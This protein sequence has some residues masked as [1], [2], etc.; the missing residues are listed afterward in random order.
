MFDTTKRDPKARSSSIKWI[1]KHLARDKKKFIIMVVGIIITIVFRTIIPYFIGLMIDEAILPRDMD[2]LATYAIIILGVGLVRILISYITIYITN[3]VAWET[4]K[5]IRVEFF[6]KMQS[7]PLKFHNTVR[8]GDLMALATNDMNQLGYMV[9]PGIRLM[10]EAFLG[11]IAVI[12]FTTSL[13]ARFTLYLSPFFI[14]YLIAV[15]SY[16]RKMNPISQTF[17]YKWSLISRSAQD[18]ITGVR[19]VRAFNGEEFEQ[20]QF[21]D[22]V[23]DFKNAWDKRQMITAKYWPLLIIY[24]TIGFSFV[25]GVWLVITGGLTLGEL[26]GIN[27]ML[28][29]LIMPTFIISFVITMFQS[30]LAGGERIFHT[31]HAAEAEEGNNK[32]IIDWPDSVNGEIIFKDV[33]FKYEGT[34]KYVLKNINLTILPGETVAIVGP[35]GS[36]KTTLT[37]LASRFYNYEGN[38]L[39]DG[40]DIQKYRLRELRQN[41]G[42]VEQDIFLFAS[43][44]YDNIR[45]GTG[46]KE[47]TQEEIERATRTSQAHEFIL[48]QPEGYETLLGE[49]GVGL[50]G[51]QKQRIAIAR[52]LLT[53]PPILI[54]DDSTSAIDSETEEK[55]A[56]AMDKVM[57]DRTT[58]LITH[59]LSAIRKADKIVVLKNG[60]IMSLGKH[61][62]LLTSSEEYRRIFSRHIALPPLKGG[63]N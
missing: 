46:D 22:V 16:N 45:F 30:G 23:D 42:R 32:K 35:T 11:L 13:N 10:A 2:R 21:Y 53:D 49:R 14:I 37:K 57:Q 40:V 54:F 15:R 51:G 25:V 1:I 8:S 36:G 31:M 28:L 7:K 3:S 20:N 5:E 44:I 60:E 41:I 34:E 61:D 24:V 55:I 9:N 56:D 43:S 50:S 58:F 19:V 26:I 63:S 47:I 17:M 52:C 29:L 12:A 33:N 62:D 27:G 48:E 6:E 38:I 4:I 18:S 59:R 39:M